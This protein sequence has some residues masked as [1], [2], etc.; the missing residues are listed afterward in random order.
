LTVP[1]D[2]RAIE[3]LQVQ[4]HLAL[5][6]GVELADLQ[7]DGDQAPQGS[8]EEQQIEVEVV[9]VD[10]HPLL[11]G[12]EG[13]ALADLEEERLDV[14]QDR[15]FQ[16][17][18]QVGVVEAESV[19]DQGIAECVAGDRRPLGNLRV[20]DLAALVR[21]AGDRGRSS[22]TLRRLDEASSA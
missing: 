20:G 10:G 14:P 22:R 8:A 11:A 1:A 7:L 3:P 4:L 6:P 19:E 21:L 15:C 12:D 2:C 16:V 13:E 5:E 17:L 18:L 9:A